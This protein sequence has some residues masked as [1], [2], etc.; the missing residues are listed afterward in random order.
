MKASLLVWKYME[1]LWQS[2]P[3]GAVCHAG[4]YTGRSST[5]AP[6]LKPN[7]MKELQSEVPTLVRLEKNGLGNLA[8]LRRQKPG[9][10]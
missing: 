3:A 7:C 4:A 6:K 10:G 1:T 9:F 5:K 2:F 8:P